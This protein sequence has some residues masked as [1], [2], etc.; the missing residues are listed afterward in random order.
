MSQKRKIEIFS[1]GCG[2]CEETIQMVEKLACASC[3]VEVLDMQDK[4]VAD[5]AK[6][7]GVRS[8]PAVAIE[9]KLVDCCVGGGPKE[10]DLLAAGLG[11]AL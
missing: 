1:A 7:L 11:Q 9:G 4:Q 8:V 3:Q 6:K 5:R 10:S 2:I